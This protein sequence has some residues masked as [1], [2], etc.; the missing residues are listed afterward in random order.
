VWA[1]T[2]CTVTA[3]ETYP[4]AAVQDVDV[5]RLTSQLLADLLSC[6]RHPRSDAWQGD[7]RDAIACA[8]VAWLHRHDL[9]RLGGP[10]NEAPPEEGWIWLPAAPA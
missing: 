5:A 1:D 6:E 3:L 9:P 4:A 10:R 7:V 2:D 8:L